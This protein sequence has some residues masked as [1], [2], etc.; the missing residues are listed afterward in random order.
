[1]GRPA[2]MF[3]Q[4]LEEISQAIGGRYDAALENC[5]QDWPSSGA[6][7][8]NISAAAAKALDDAAPT[9]TDKSID[10]V[11]APHPSIQFH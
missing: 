2:R 5:R 10:D 7:N 4:K 3:L 1:M 8:A 6:A 11:V 9:L